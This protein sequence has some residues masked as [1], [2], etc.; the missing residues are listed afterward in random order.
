LQGTLRVTDRGR[1]GAIKWWHGWMPL[2]I[3]PAAVISFLAGAAARWVL[4]WA[5]AFAIYSGCKWLT[6]R[7]TAV[8]NVPAW[9]NAAY[10]VAWPGLDAAAFLGNASAGRVHRR[11]WIRGIQNI[12]VGLGL[13]FGIARLVVVRNSYLAGWIGM[14]GIVLV[15]H[16]GAFELLSCVWRQVGIQARPLMNKP[17]L[18]QSLGEF[19]GRRWNTAFR[20]LTHRFLFRPLTRRFGVSAGVAGGFVF[21]GLVHDL[22]ISGPASGGWGGPTVFFAIQGAGILVERSS[23]GRKSGL[24]TGTIGRL[25]A[26]AALLVPAPLLFHRPFVETIVIPFMQALGAL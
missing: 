7:R 17:L 12:A 16:F 1:A 22:V 23:F 20:D 6:W 18:S 9:R 19:W 3:L 13:F 11:D 25:F 4:M 10:L 24:G 26:A 2:V 15:L 21:S 5:L 14:T 8:G